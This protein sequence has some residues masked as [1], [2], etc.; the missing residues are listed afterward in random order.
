MVALLQGKG[1]MPSLDEVKAIL[2]PSGEVYRG[3]QSV[4]TASI[5]GSEGRHADFDRRFR[6]RKRHTRRRWMS[7]FT[8]HERLVG[9]PAVTL[10]ELGGL[11]FVR[12][13]NHRVSVARHRGVTFI[14]AE[15]T[16]L[17]SRVALS[18]GMSTDDM[19]KAVIR[20]EH[21]RFAEAL[22]GS[23]EVPGAE[24]AFTE[25]GGFDEVLRHVAGHRE[26]LRAAGRPVADPVEAAR[27]WYANVY[28]LL[29]KVIRDAGIMKYLPGR[30]TA[31][32][33][34][35][36]VRNWDEFARRI[37]QSGSRDPARR[38]FRTWFLRGRGIR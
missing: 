2:R 31:D 10:Y 3:L 33:Y 16:S 14:D 5:A 29:V 38:R 36:V 27:S 12:D 37:G 25:V 1:T 15:V 28:L 22:L 24:L 17:S 7:I 23:E 26:A 4:P 9:L 19:R 20:W 8:A 21:A 11:Y 35:W 32:L 13:G 34:L 6:P 18:A 30:T